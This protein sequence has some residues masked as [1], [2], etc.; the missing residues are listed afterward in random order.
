MRFA[1]VRLDAGKVDAGVEGFLERRREE[2]EEAK[3]G[4]RDR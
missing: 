1:N 2:E 3:N 4:Y